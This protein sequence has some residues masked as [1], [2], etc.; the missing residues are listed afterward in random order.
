MAVAAFLVWL[1][2]LL[3][4]CESDQAVVWQKTLRFLDGSSTV[5]AK[6]TQYS[7]PGTAAVFTSVEM[8]RADE[9]RKPV[10]ILVFEVP[11]DPNPAK[12]TVDMSWIDARHLDIT[13]PVDAKLSFRADI[14]G[15]INIRSHPP[16]VN[17]KKSW[18]L[19]ACR[20]YR[21]HVNSVR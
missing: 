12:I 6:T 15:D 17:R 10:E 2:L 7:G 14:Y 19:F 9:E 5:V 11:N 4:G 13:Y 16:P 21:L 20:R 18:Y 8:V 3:C 1:L